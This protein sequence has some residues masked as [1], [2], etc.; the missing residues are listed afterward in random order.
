MNA[1]PLLAEGRCW[2]QLS[3]MKSQGLSTLQDHDP[4]HN[5]TV[6]DPIQEKGYLILFH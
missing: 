6:V 5:G 4:F 2:N 3:L 1:A